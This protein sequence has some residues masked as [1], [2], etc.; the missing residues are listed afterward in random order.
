MTL[1]TAC[2]AEGSGADQWLSSVGPA[3]R[4]GAVSVVV[5]EVRGQ[6]RDE[7]LG[8]CEVAAFQEATC[9]SAEPQLDLVEPGAVFGGVVE[10]M[11]VFGVGKEG[12]TLRA[13]AQ[14]FLVE[15]Q[16]VESSQEFANVKAP[17]GVQVV[18]DPMEALVFGELR[19]DMVQM[20]GEIDTGACHA[21]IPHDLAGGHDQ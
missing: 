2:L 15:G 20:S 16:A 3:V 10:H 1:L 12:A 11:L 13:G 4:V 18:E 7:V 9:Q 17:M 14:V 8:G 19:G 6:A 5:V 21:Q